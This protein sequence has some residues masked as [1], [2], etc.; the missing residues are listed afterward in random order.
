MPTPN[1]DALVAKIRNWANKRDAATVDNE[2]VADCIKFGADD[3]HR[4]LRIPQLEFTNLIVVESSFNTTPGLTNIPV[5][6]DLI[7]FIWLAKLKLDGSVDFTYDNLPDIRTFL[8]P[9]AENYSAQ[10]YCWTGLNFMIKPQLTVGERIQLHYYRRLPKMDALY[11]VTP[12]NYSFEF[13][14]DD[15]PLLEL[16]ALNGT[17]MFQVLGGTTDAIF[18]TS[19]EANAYLVTNGG[20]VVTRMY[21]GREAWNW[22]RDANEKIILWATLRHIGSFLDLNDM[23]ARYEARLGNEIEKLNREEKMRKVKGGNIQM[24]VNANGMI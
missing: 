13:D 17:N 16:V 7:E 6:E 18:S 19:A 10:R 4:D 22:L 5:P 9:N 1:Y 15:Q 20:A 8:N 2:T 11:A 12:E 23:E 3:I 24:N 14:F 21:I